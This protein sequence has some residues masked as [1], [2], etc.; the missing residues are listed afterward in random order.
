MAWAC[1]WMDSITSF[2]GKKIGV[3][4]HQSAEHIL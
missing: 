2:C 4:G 1:E 3:A